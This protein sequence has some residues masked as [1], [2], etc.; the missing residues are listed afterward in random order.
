MMAIAR[1]VSVA[2]SCLLLSACAR[3][4]DPARVQLRARL[5]QDAPLSNDELGRTLD[6]VSRALAGKTVRF[7]QEA[8]TRDLDAPQREAVLGILTNRAGVFDEGV[9]SAG[10]ATLRVMNAPGRASNAELDAARRLFIDADTFLPRR[11]EFS[12][13]VS[14]DEYAFDLVVQP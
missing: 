5:K 10:G 9:E 4:E 11:F 8:V 1:A 6:E 12:S 2:V 3:P 14:S 7:T 13:G